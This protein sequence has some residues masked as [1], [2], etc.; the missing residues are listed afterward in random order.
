MEVEFIFICRGLLPGADVVEQQDSVS[1]ADGLKLEDL[2]DRAPQA[3]LC[4]LGLRLAEEFQQW[5]RF[6]MDVP[7][8]T[9]GGVGFQVEFQLVAGLQVDG[10]AFVRIR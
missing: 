10:S 6:R 7:H 5:R 4:G 1:C 9:R 2:E 8:V 3:G